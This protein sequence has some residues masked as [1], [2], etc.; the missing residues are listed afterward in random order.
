MYQADKDLKTKGLAFTERWRDILGDRLNNGVLLRTTRLPYTIEATM[1]K[2]DD[3]PQIENAQRQY[4]TFMDIVVTQESGRVNRFEYSSHTT[5]MEQGLE[6]LEG[7]EPDV[8]SNFVAPCH[9]DGRINSD[10][11]GTYTYTESAQLNEVAM[12]VMSELDREHSV[13]K[14]DI[15][16][17]PADYGKLPK[18]FWFN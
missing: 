2:D 5:V 6:Y 13:G 14:L 3:L 16:D 8:Y 17:V 12:R 10:G 1:R 7:V 9:E 18:S 15:I 4:M 11:W